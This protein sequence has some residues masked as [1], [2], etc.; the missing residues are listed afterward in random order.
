MLKEG[1]K[2]KLLE[3]LSNFDRF[4]NDLFCDN[5]ETMQLAR[6][7]QS[8]V[9]K[10]T[11]QYTLLKDI[12]ADAQ[13]LTN[14]TR[15]PSINY[16][17]N[18]EVYSRFYLNLIRLRILV[19]NNEGRFNNMLEAE[20]KTVLVSE[21]ATISDLEHIT[22]DDKEKVKYKYLLDEIS[23]VT[24]T[25]VKKSD[26]DLTMPD[27]TDS[28]NSDDVEI[29]VHENTPEVDE[30]D[31]F[32]RVQ[33]NDD[34]PV[35][36]MVAEPIETS[37]HEFSE[38]DGPV[39]T[40]EE[41]VENADVVIED[42]AIINDDIPSYEPEP[43]IEAD[44][45]S[46]PVLN[47]ES[48][49]I[50]DKPIESTDYSKPV[51]EEAEPDAED[52]EEIKPKAKRPLMERP[53]H[54]AERAK[55]E[56]KKEPM[57]GSLMGKFNKKDTEPVEF[58]PSLDHET[59]IGEECMV[60]EKIVFSQF[61]S[62][63]M[64]PGISAMITKKDEVYI[65]YSRNIQKNVYDNSDHDIFLLKNADR[66]VYQYFVSDLLTLDCEV[67][68][69]IKEKISFYGEFVE[70]LYK[71]LLALNEVSV[72][73]F[74]AWQEY[75]GEAVDNVIYMGLD[76][77]MR[78]IRAMKVAYDLIEYAELFNVAHPSRK[79]IVA[80]LSEGDVKR[81][82]NLINEIIEKKT[83]KRSSSEEIL[84]HLL[85]EILY[86]QYQKFIDI[87][88][89]KGNQAMQSVSFE[90]WQSVFLDQEV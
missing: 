49:H 28:V 18:L 26:I 59:R 89:I 41:I 30:K 33:K 53:S 72:N 1:E 25:A 4:K 35:Q 45:P 58:K 10:R 23:K 67:D 8:R 14:D 81:T 2:R 77:K 31:D 64:F 69:E 17:L 19:K 16:K 20:Y 39:A 37:V 61:H 11:D 83:I 54:A 48:T 5:S 85:D 51:I 27:M 66:S 86:E 55:K 76:S 63:Y 40:V 3:V 65:G 57:L 24:N 87:A 71:K 90:E 12:I 29:S 44:E 21:A 15:K 47:E 42:T 34:L 56:K 70:W 68:D 43:I 38:Y 84:K 6:V 22:N 78:K 82:Y 62:V 32:L 88:V 50:E 74:T 46:Y 7:L 52:V 13:S 9:E 36:E 80:E 73:N 79:E 60:E 75:Y